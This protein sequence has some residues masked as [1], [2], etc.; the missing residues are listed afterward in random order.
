MARALVCAMLLA[1]AATAAA[2]P[3]EADRA[4]ARTLFD[5]GVAALRAENYPDALAAFEQSWQLNP[6]PLVMY[7]IAMCRRA[8]FDYPAAIGSFG[9]YLEVAAGTS[10]PEDRQADARTQIAEL[11][12]LVGQVAL[13][14]EPAGARVLVDGREV[15][16]TPLAEPLRVGPG[17]HVIEVRRDGYEELRRE[18]TVEQGERVE[19]VATLAPAQATVEPPVVGP[20]PPPPV[21]PLPEVETEDEGGIA[22]QWWFWTIIGVVVVGGGVTAGVL[23]WPSDEGPVDDWVLHGP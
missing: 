23:L 20:V 2:E 10:E 8:L 13:A 19:L 4:R 21:E 22:T 1:S 17:Q 15:G 16:T 18:V 5:A 14:V 9:T 3:T 12:R 11:E 6:R 7:N